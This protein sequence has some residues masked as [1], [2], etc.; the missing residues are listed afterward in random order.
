MSKTESRGEI[1]MGTILEVVLIALYFAALVSIPMTPSPPFRAEL[2]RCQSCFSALTCF[3]L[4]RGRK[5]R[6]IVAFSP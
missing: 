5:S 1:S 2:A 3:Y 6:V 4:L